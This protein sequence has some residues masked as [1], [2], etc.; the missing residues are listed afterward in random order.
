MNN[1]KEENAAHTDA[2]SSRPTDL[3]DSD[4]QD[5]PQLVSRKDDATDLEFADHLSS[6]KTH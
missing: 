6:N 4:Q 5:Q 1:A 3:A 2:D